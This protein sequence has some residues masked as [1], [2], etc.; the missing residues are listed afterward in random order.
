MITSI[1]LNPCI[2]AVIK[3]KS[4]KPGHFDV[5]PVFIPAGSGINSVVII[6]KLRKSGI[7][8]KNTKA[9]YSGFVD[10][11]KLKKLLKKKKV[12]GKYC[13]PVKEESRINYT[14]VPSK[15]DEMHLKTD[16]PRITKTDYKK[17]ESLYDKIIEDSNVIIISGKLPLNAENNYYNN[18]IKK[19]ND[20]RVYTVLDTRG[21]TLK[22][23]VKAGPFMVKCNLTELAFLLNKNSI[24]STADIIKAGNIFA[25]NNIQLGVISAGK[26]GIYVIYKGKFIAQYM[27]PE[28]IN[29]KSTTGAGDIIL[30]Y[31]S[32][33][34]DYAKRGIKKLTKETINEHARYSVAYASASTL[35]P[36][37]SVFNIKTAGTFLK[38]VTSTKNINNITLS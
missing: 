36:Y 3:V 19:A 33:L 37:P 1:G 8:D 26:N 13:V 38:K 31:F 25:K 7:I 35:T 10:N 32:L 22:T 28:K 4:I 5:K 14:I 30:V 9:F 21:D 16:G 27:L 29:I 24:N 20:S 18:F 6:D 12:S 34:L 15:G 17:F 11:G 23:A 2:D